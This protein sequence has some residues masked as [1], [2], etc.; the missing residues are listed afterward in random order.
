ML[1][2][3]GVCTHYPVADVQLSPSREF[4]KLRRPFLPLGAPK[5]THKHKD[6]ASRITL[7]LDFKANNWDIFVYVICTGT[8][9]RPIV[10]K[11]EFDRHQI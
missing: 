11:A 8:T 3:S 6:P 7:L 10:L 4:W 1:F 2:S 5:A 9:C